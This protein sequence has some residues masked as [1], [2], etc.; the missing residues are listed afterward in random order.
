MIPSNQHTEE[1][2]II[3]FYRMKNTPQTLNH[4]DKKIVETPANLD[5]TL[6][7][8]TSGATTNRLTFWILFFIYIDFMELSGRLNKIDDGY[9]VE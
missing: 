8:L 4:W 6:Y 3:L 1:V 5:P 2:L 7:V 9:H